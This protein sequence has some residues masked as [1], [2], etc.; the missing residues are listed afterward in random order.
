MFN[1]AA[2]DV[3][4]GLVFVYL[5]YSLLCT[6]IVEIISSYT[7]FRG[8]L[9]QKAIERMLDDGATSQKDDPESEGA[10]EVKQEKK[11]AQR[12]PG[13]PP[14]VSAAFFAHPLIKYLRADTIFVKK[15]PSYIDP[16]T[17]TKVLIDLLRG[18]EA[19]AGGTDRHLIERSLKDGQ[20]A[21]KVVN[22]KLVGGR[23][24]KAD[25]KHH[26]QAPFAKLEDDT[27][28]YLESVWVDAQGDV[29][30]FRGF[31]VDWF[32]EMMDRTT[33]WY[34]KYTQLML[35]AIGFVIAAL[36]NVD[37]IKIARLLEA[38]PELRKQIVSQV[39]SFTQKNPDLARNLADLQQQY[40]DLTRPASNDQA[41]NKRYSRKRDS[42]QRLVNQNPVKKLQ[43][44]ES[45]VLGDYLPD[46]A[47]TLGI[48]YAGGF[49]PNFE[50]YSVFGW[51]FTALAISMGA[52][53]WFDL[54][55]KLMQLRSSLAPKEDAAQ[56]PKA[57]G[58]PKPK[59]IDG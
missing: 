5:L 34:K 12:A 45:K 52:S 49:G 56:K 28:M 42:L 51:L 21:W 8:W 18:P 22:E 9:L 14:K 15:K 19:T 58:G 59:K 25:D 11:A 40:S 33:G 36:L 47:H 16:D 57:D 24:L 46:A 30:K 10:D 2:L 29:S 54:L 43:D 31:I 7:G 32:N 55:N 38:K 17:F 4:I 23:Y 41:G 44:E 39:S 6:I 13:A 1:N 35:L 27:C 26:Q 50:W 3:V 37:T 48:G 20:I 53:F